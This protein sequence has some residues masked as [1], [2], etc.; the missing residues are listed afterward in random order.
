MSFMAGAWALLK[1]RNGIYGAVIVAM[2][3]FLLVSHTLSYWAGKGAGRNAE[4]AQTAQV[5]G[6]RNEKVRKKLRATNK[7]GAA[8]R[9]RKQW[10]FDC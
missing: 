3:A 5:A 8:D 1:S 7:P 9:L 6:V 10:C 2:A 4:R